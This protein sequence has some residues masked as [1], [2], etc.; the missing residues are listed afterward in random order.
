ML[1]LIGH[2]VYSEFHYQEEKHLV[3]GAGGVGCRGGLPGAGGEVVIK[4]GSLYVPRVVVGGGW[5]A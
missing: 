5:G 3:W 1:Y 2:T 4:R